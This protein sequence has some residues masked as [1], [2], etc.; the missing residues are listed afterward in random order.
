MCET[1]ATSSS[2]TSSTSTAEATTSSSVASSSTTTST[3]L[4]GLGLIDL[5]LLAIQ[6]HSVHL[7]DGGVSGVL[8][9]EGDEGIALAGVVD[10]GHCAELLE[11]SLNKNF[12]YQKSSLTDGESREY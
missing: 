8:V 5:D 4:T 12:K 7:T 6:G 9:V 1:Y 10:I 11:L 3:S 2:E